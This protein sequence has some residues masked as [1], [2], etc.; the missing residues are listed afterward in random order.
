MAIDLMEVSA[1]RV[2]T[3]TGALREYAGTDV[4][5]HL[6]QLL[7]ALRMVYLHDLA[8]VTPADL[9]AKQGALRQVIALE[10]ALSSDLVDTPRI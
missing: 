5:D 2:R 9:L 4:F 10:R 7:S 6:V 1:D 8:D 3:H